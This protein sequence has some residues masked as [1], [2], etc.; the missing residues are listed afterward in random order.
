MKL[1]EKLEL[2]LIPPQILT[3]KKKQQAFKNYMTQ[4][5]RIISVQKY[6]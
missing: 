6:Y 1:K 4:W 2:F 5:K 3:L